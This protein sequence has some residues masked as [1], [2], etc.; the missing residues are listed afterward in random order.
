MSKKINQ[1]KK[2]NIKLQ[3]NQSFMIEDLSIFLHIQR[4]YANFLRG[5]CSEEDKNIY[6]KIVSAINDSIENVFITPVNGDQNE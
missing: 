1:R 3:N 2:I 6:T 4:T 5:I